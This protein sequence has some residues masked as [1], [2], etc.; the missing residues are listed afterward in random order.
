MPTRTVSNGFSP[1]QYLNIFLLRSMNKLNIGG[2]RKKIPVWEFYHRC[3]NA[4]CT[5]YAVW[6]HCT[7]YHPEYSHHL[8]E[9]MKGFII[10]N[11]LKT[12][13]VCNHVMSTHPCGHKYFTG[14]CNCRMRH[15]REE[16]LMGQG[17]SQL[18]NKVEDSDSSISHFSDFMIANKKYNK[19][20]T[21]QA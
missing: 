9:G 16:T 8:L 5:E 18:R 10:Y 19:V 11:R 3:K 2:G 20:H 21:H 14:F 12:S 6:Y 7:I 1:A 17:G 13:S 15:E 4:T